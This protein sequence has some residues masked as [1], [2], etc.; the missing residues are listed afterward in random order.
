MGQGASRRIGVRRMRK[1]IISACSHMKRQAFAKNRLCIH[2]SISP[3]L[4]QFHLVP[5]V[6]LFQEHHLGSPFQRFSN[7]GEFYASATS[8]IQCG[9]RH[10]ITFP[11][12]FFATQY[13]GADMLQRKCR[14]R[15]PLPVGSDIFMPYHILKVVMSNKEL[16]ELQGLSDLDFRVSMPPARLIVQLV[17]SKDDLVFRIQR[18]EPSLILVATFFSGPALSISI[19]ME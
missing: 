10:F 16:C 12:F 5:S 8:N 15:I 18:P 9:S 7:R 13:R 1:A 14:A 19:P 17:F 4:H 3:F 6:A 2:P 11:F